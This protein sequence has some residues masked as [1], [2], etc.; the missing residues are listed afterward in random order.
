MLDSDYLNVQQDDDLHFLATAARLISGL[1]DPTLDEIVIVRVRNWFDH[2]WLR[3]SGYGR[4]PFEGASSSHPGVALD[5]FSQDKLT[6]PP[7]TPRRIVVETHF[8]KLDRTAESIRWIHRRRVQEHSAHNLH[9]RVEDYSTSL[10]IAWVSTGSEPTGRASVMAYTSKDGTLD[11]WYASFKRGPSCWQ[12]D[13]VKGTDRNHVVNLLGEP[14]PPR[15]GP[16]LTS[17]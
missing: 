1:D 5:A 17:H 4:V 15:S 8:T 13:R 3:F 16:V 11:A 7:F 9:R 14:V 2:K 6:F 12:L 10:L